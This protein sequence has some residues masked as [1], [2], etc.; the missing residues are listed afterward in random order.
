MCQGPTL[1]G[2]WS[3]Q[4]ERSHVNT[5]RNGP[6]GPRNMMRDDEEMIGG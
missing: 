4:P 6:R 2:R 1:P 5:P 3:G